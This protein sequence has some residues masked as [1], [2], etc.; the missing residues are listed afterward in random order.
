MN[1]GC[2]LSR[3]SEMAPLLVHK[4]MPFSASV[5]IQKLIGCGGGGIGIQRVLRLESNSVL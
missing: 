3:T 5:E 2:R 1:A 4:L